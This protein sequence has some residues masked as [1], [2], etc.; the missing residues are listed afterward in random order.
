LP[1]KQFVAGSPETIDHPG[2][3]VSSQLEVEQSPSSESPS[4]RRF[5]LGRPARSRPKTG[6]RLAEKPAADVPLGADDIA[7]AAAADANTA[8]ERSTALT[9]AFT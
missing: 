3:V 6:V 9:G 1:A 8:S 2:F 5:E 7:G 4:S